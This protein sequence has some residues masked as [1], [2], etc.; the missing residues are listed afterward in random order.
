MYPY[1]PIYTKF[2][3]LDINYI[4][5]IWMKYKNFLNTRYLDEQKGI[6]FI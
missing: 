2:D 6:Y 5:S 4:I 3:I 1:Y